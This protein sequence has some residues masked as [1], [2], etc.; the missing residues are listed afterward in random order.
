MSVLPQLYHQP[1]SV[2]HLMS[3]VTSHSPKVNIRRILRERR[4]GLKVG[5]EKEVERRISVS[6]VSSLLNQPVILPVRTHV[7]LYD[8]VCEC[9]LSLQSNWICL[10]LQ[11]LFDS[12]NLAVSGKTCFNWINLYDKNKCLWSQ[13][14]RVYFFV[15][16]WLKVFKSVTSGRMQLTCQGISGE[17]A[18]LCDS[19]PT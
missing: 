4:G 11:C 19:L 6:V 16:V 2:S 17:M 13:R 1:P 9:L 3:E 18:A 8:S 12:V 15:C 10:Q 5:W 7:H 14:K